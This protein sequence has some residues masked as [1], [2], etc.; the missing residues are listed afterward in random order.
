MENK[1]NKNA[2]I[3]NTPPVTELSLKTSKAFIGYIV[4]ALII[5]I[6]AIG[7]FLGKG[8]RGSVVLDNENTN[9][10]TTNGVDNA[11]SST[12]ASS[13][14]NNP[15]G[16]DMNGSGQNEPAK[17]AI[18][19]GYQSPIS[20]PLYQEHVVG[21]ENIS[22]RVQIYAWAVLEDS[23]CPVDVQCI[24]AGRVRVA[25]RFANPETKKDLISSQVMEVDQKVK[26]NGLEI[27]LLEVKPVTRSTVKIEDK[28]YRF[29]FSIAKAK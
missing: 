4:V 29:I 18:F 7:L 17:P 16:N 2:E 21:G 19:T 28:D 5:I 15:G 1:E 11:M 20:V 9:A 27:T 14:D 10:T 26:V 13:T 25:V 3:K 22:Q 8:N 23:R 12:T 24:Q 6:A